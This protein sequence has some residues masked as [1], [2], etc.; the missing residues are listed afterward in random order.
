MPHG[1]STCN[2]GAICTLGVF[3]TWPVCHINTR[4]IWIQCICRYHEQGWKTTVMYSIQDI[5]ALPVLNSYINRAP[6]FDFLI[7]ASHGAQCTTITNLSHWTCYT[8]KCLFHSKKRS[9]HVH[10][11]FVRSARTSVRNRELVS[12]LPGNGG[13]NVGH[14]WQSGPWNKWTVIR[15]WLWENDSNT[16]IFSK[17]PPSLERRTWACNSIKKQMFGV[18]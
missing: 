18:K 9:L 16:A 6:V 10:Q 8:C 1:C 12:I 3:K 17:C 15:Y 5:N 4:T 11:S 13:L 2:S 14:G 7:T